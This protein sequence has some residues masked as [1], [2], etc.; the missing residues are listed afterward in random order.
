MQI[1]LLT[2]ASLLYIAFSGLTVTPSLSAS[3]GASVT[4][5]RNFDS[6]V[7]ATGSL[8]LEF[9]LGDDGGA[10]LRYGLSRQAATS[11]TDD[12][13]RYRG[14]SGL[15]MGAGYYHDF[16]LVE[17]YA[18]GGG[19]L[20]KYEN[21]YSYFWFPFLELGGSM[22]VA[23]LGDRIGVQAGL[24]IPVYLRADAVTAG[25]RATVSFAL[26]PSFRDR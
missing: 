22:P 18:L 10:L 15:A 5:Q 4:D 9:R 7:G 8:D 14:F 2:L 11:Y 6:A 13:Y 16:G 21:S 19:Q 26:L 23:R 3:A 24:A 25:A 20:A 17:A 1:T 12:W